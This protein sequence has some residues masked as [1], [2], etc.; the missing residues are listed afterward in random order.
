MPYKFQYAPRPVTPAATMDNQIP[1][2]IVQERYERLV[3]RQNA[4][5]EQENQALIGTEVEV[6]ITQ[7]GGRKDD[8]TN[9]V[10][11]SSRDDGRVHIT[12]PEDAHGPAALLDAETSHPRAPRLV[13]VVKAVITRAA[14]AHLVAD[15]A[16]TTG[17][18][19]L[20][21]TQAGDAW[22]AQERGKLTSAGQATSNGGGPVGVSLGM[23]T[24]R[25]S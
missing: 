25:E 1:R 17:E 10:S 16:L 3:E 6:L 15:S 7:G 14:P 12:L 22:A 19:E 13:A 9:R 20:R 24:V 21:R 18:F 23:P 5:S 2:E 4:I 11:G 8:R